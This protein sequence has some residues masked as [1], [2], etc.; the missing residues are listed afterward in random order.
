M[1]CSDQRRWRHVWVGLAAVLKVSTAH[2]GQHAPAPHRALYQIGQLGTLWPQVGHSLS[3]S[4]LLPWGLCIHQEG[5]GSVRGKVA[6]GQSWGNTYKHLVC[7]LQYL[8]FQGQIMPFIWWWKV[9]SLNGM[10]TGG[11]RYHP[12]WAEALVLVGLGSAESLPWRNLCVIPHL[13]LFLTMLAHVH[14]Y[15]IIS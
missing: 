15:Q 5:A 4:H 11:A 9:L 2:W 14:I 10:K 3:P 6:M 13:D 8:C 12:V 7:R 1:F